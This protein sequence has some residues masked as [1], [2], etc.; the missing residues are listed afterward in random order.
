MSDQDQVE[1]RLQ[2]AKLR[3]NH[4]DFGAAIDAM[5]TC[6]CDM[7]QIQRMKKKKLDIKDRIAVLESRVI[8]N[9]IA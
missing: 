9:I 5:I 3:Q 2:I 8:P 4:D 1:L 6:K 7:L